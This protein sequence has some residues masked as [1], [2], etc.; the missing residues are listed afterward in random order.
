MMDPRRSVIEKRLGEV[1]RIVAFCSAKGGVGKTFC[2]SLS[3]LLLARA[4]AGTPSAIGLFDLDFQGASAH[5]V[6]GEK[7]RLPIEKEG[8]LPGRTS[9]GVLLLSAAAFTGERAFPLRGPEVTAAVL[10]LFAVTRWGPLE[11]L[12][13]DMPPGIGDE[14]LDLLSMIPRLEVL[15]VSTPSAVSTA[16]VDRLI[17]LLLEVDAGVLGVMANM[18]R[19]DAGSVQDLAGR[20]GIDYLGE[21]PFD[22]LAEE[23]IGRPAGLLECAASQALEGVLVRAGLLRAP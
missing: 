5:I 11:T 1:G 15:V 3:A 7:P 23:E 17:G 18:S 21:V 12:I 13:L 10:E 4:A 2:A 8:I 6:L 22:P 19:G 20:Y 9:T 14:I 16:V